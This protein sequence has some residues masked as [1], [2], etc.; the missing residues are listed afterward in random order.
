MTR[1]APCTSLPL[2]RIAEPSEINRVI[3]IGDSISGQAADDP[4]LARERP[5]WATVQDIRTGRA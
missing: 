2:L 5:E 4:V 1:I 3:S